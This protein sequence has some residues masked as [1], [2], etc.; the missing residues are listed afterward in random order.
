MRVLTKPD[1]LDE[2]PGGN[3]TRAKEVYDKPVVMPIKVLSRKNDRGIHAHHR[4]G[5]YRQAPTDET[6]N[7]KVVIHVEVLDG[8]CDDMS[9]NRSRDDPGEECDCC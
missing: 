2:D 4:Q 1:E 5:N 3:S 8:K 7:R 9:R 6:H